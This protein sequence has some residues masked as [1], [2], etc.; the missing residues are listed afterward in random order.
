M[1]PLFRSAFTPPNTILGATGTYVHSTVRLLN[2]A[3]VSVPAVPL[4]VSRRC[5]DPTTM[6]A[7]L[8][9]W[10]AIERWA[11]EIWLSTSLG[12]GRAQR[13][14][15]HEGTQASLG[16]GRLLL[17]HW[18]RTPGG[19]RDRHH[20]FGLKQ[21][22]PLLFSIADNGKECTMDLTA[23]SPAMP[24]GMLAHFVTATSGCI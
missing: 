20:F 3:G 8:M 10:A 1:P 13:R 9:H 6:P 15:Q 24:K 7:F 17:E 21:P 5:I 16:R 11:K 12:S 22:A 14:S 4:E 2:V 19:T 18:S 23:G